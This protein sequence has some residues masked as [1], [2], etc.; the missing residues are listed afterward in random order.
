MEG[1]PEGDN[2]EWVPVPG[3]R[4]E[5][6]PGETPESLPRLES[7]LLRCDECISGRRRLCLPPDPV[8]VP[9]C[10]SSLARAARLERA[11]PCSWG[12]RTE[13][14]GVRTSSQLTLEMRS[15]RVREGG[16][17]VGPTGY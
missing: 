9:H 11:C 4:R 13:G 12:C 6:V 17:T 7:Y 2:R 8:S 10:C 3:E 15:A 1:P 14:E 16:G 5:W